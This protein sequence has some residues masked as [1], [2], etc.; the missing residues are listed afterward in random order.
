MMPSHQ[1]RVSQPR[2]RMITKTKNIDFEFELVIKRFHRIKISAKSAE[3]AK[4][5][6]LHYAGQNYE[7]MESEDCPEFEINDI[8]G[9]FAE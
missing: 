7:L 3:E 9:D 5:K 2:T 1:N 6:A 8:Y 4:A